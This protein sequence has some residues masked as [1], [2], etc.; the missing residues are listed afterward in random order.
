MDADYHMQYRVRWAGRL[1]SLDGV[2][3]RVSAQCRGKI[4]RIM[5]VMADIRKRKQAEEALLRAEKLAVAGRLAASVAH[6]INIRHAR[7]VQRIGEF[8]SRPFGSLT[9]SWDARSRS[10]RR[11]S[12]RISGPTARCRIPGSSTRW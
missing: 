12:R 7:L 8:M 2:S 10:P 3:G 11:T 1:D 9:Q 5:G 6:E 4:V